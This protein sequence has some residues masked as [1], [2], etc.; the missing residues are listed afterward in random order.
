MYQIRGPL[1]SQGTPEL[2][3]TS[4]NLADAYGMMIECRRLANMKNYHVYQLKGSSISRLKQFIGIT[5]SDYTG[6]LTLLDHGKIIVNDVTDTEC[7]HF[8]NGNRVKP[9]HQSLFQNQSQKGE[10]N[11]EIIIYSPS[12]KT[13]RNFRSLIGSEIVLEGLIGMG[14]STLGNC[15][16]RA[17]FT[18]KS[19]LP[20]T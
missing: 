6:K 5:P 1:M 14:K 15:Q 9:I 8:I 20:D 13:D 7:N 19:N 18:Y 4:K 2:I 10:T 12:N 3:Y 16:I 11:D 17:S